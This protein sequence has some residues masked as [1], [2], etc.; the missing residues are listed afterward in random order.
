MRL[1]KRI[2]GEGVYG[3]GLRKVH[4]KERTWRSRRDVRLSAKEPIEMTVKA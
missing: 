1:C 3:G 2:R 4:S